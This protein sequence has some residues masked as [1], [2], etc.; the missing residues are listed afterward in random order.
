MVENDL[1]GRNHLADLLPLA[2][3]MDAKSRKE[4]APF[5]LEPATNVLLLRLLRRV[6]LGDGTNAHGTSASSARALA[7][8]AIDGKVCERGASS[9]HDDD[10][11][12]Q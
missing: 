11:F 3:S 8:T 1:P 12:G 9:Q 10:L 5:M 4:R 7:S 2:S 6:A